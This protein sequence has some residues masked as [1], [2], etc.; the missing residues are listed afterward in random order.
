M[1]L[2]DDVSRVGQHPSRWLGIGVTQ[3]HGAR[4]IQAAM[5]L[6][7]ERL[8]SELRGT[9]PLDRRCHHLCITGAYIGL[10]EL[11]ARLQ[12]LLPLPLPNTVS[13]ELRLI[14]QTR[15]GYIYIH[16]PDKARQGAVLL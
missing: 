12:L 6:Q 5:S 15:H 4:T 8:E 3:R 2:D 1:Q 16:Q 11:K 7:L 10:V 13:G 9:S 14:L